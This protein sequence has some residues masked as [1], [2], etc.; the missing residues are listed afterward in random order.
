MANHAESG[1]GD[2]Q[3]ICA[4]RCRGHGQGHAD[5][6]TAVLSK[7]ARRGKIYVDYLRNGRGATAIS[8]YSTRARAGAPVS[9][10]LGG[11][12]VAVGALSCVHPE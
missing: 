4:S 1:L 11:C 12:T 7:S 6:Y 8:A 10:P 2:G 3:I 9:T 5:E